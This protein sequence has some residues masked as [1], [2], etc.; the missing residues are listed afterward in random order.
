LGCKDINFAILGKAGLR[1]IAQKANAEIRA[2]LNSCVKV[3]SASFMPI[4]FVFDF[5]KTKRIEVQC[6]WAIKEAYKIYLTKSEQALNTNI[7]FK[8]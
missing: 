3:I 1:K 6:F 7:I 5:T 2:S 8:R 4:N